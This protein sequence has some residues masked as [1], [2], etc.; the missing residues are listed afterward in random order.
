[1]YNFMKKSIKLFLLVFIFLGC[2][3]RKNIDKAQKITSK[4]NNTVSS[5]VEI[6]ERLNNIDSVVFVFYKDPHGADSL[7]YTR[8]Y[9][10]Y[11]DVDSSNIMLLKQQ[12]KGTV[13]K[14]EKIKKCRSEGKIWCFIK[15]NIVQT[16]YFSGLDKD[17]NFL[18]IIK[19]GMFYYTNLENTYSEK[20]LSMKAT[21]PS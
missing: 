20:I 18:C 21:K 12:L 13:E 14:L 4:K 10:Q 16:I 9:T 3:E 19:D 15:G 5:I 6:D 11:G 8:F 2:A 17:C 7:R 1:M